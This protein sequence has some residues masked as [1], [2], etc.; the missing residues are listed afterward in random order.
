MTA[1]SG[2]YDNIVLYSLMNSGLLPTDHGKSELY[3][4][5]YVAV[6]NHGKLDR[7]GTDIKPGC[8][9]LSLHPLTECLDTCF[10]LSRILLAVIRLKTKCGDTCFLQLCLGRAAFNDIGVAEL[11]AVMDD[12]LGMVLTNISLT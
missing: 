1:V 8:P 6:L 10:E 7:T 4:S 2:G 11:E 12:A 5:G 9:H 3:V